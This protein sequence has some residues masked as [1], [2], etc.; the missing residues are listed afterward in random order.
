MEKPRFP[1]QTYST[2]HMKLQ[3]EIYLREAKVMGL[4]MSPDKYLPPPSKSPVVRT[5]F[6]SVLDNPMYTSQ[7]INAPV[8]SKMNARNF[9]SSLPSNYALGNQ[10]AYNSGS[11]KSL[12]NI[13]KAR[14][15]E[16]TK[17]KAQY[18]FNNRSPVTWLGKKDP[19]TESYYSRSKPSPENSMKLASVMNSKRIL[20]GMGYNKTNI[21][22]N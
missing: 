16:A 15:G 4:S 10:G 20:K 11:S 7:E 13:Y 8:R 18:D 6:Q 1:P 21:F 17:Y 9:N 3:K 12:E 5:R 22:N 2:S 14:I 19:V